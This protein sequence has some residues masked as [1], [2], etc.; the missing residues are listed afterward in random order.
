MTAAIS[1]RPIQQEESKPRVPGRRI[2]TVAEGAEAPTTLWGNRALIRLMVHRDFIGRYKGSLLG[3]F[4][5]LINPI[6][7]L[8]LYTFL[9]SVVLKVKFGAS[10]STGNFALY[11]MAGLLPWS[12]L[13][14]SLSR[15][16]TVILESPNL[17]KRVVF[18]LQILPVV[19]VI[20]SLM[21][22]LVAFSIL[23]VA[24]VF[25]LHTVHPTIL[26]LPLIMVSQILFAGGLSCLLASLGV[27]IR[28]IRHIMALGLSAWMYATPIVYPATALPENLQFLIWINPM[29]GI[30]TDYRRVLLEGLAPNWPVY[31]SYT[32]VAVIV[33]A[34]GYG[35]FQK[36]KKSFADIM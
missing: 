27:Y 24:S 31:A 13:A 35:F 11:L 30:V 26:F 14:E 22:E 18:P 23:F 25:A 9:F 4:W 32:A 17:V 34:L 2:S 1:E 3:A 5:P 19:L 6:G 28:D 10:D 12:C 8:I 20:S 7:H 21:S 29:A 36:T 15:S 33:W 16:T